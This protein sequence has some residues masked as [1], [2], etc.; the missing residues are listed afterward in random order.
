MDSGYIWEVNVKNKNDDIAKVYPGAL[1]GTDNVLFLNLSSGYTS[2][3]YIF[4][5]TFS[6]CLK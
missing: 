5:D 1:N 2:F 6:I 3:Y 4:V